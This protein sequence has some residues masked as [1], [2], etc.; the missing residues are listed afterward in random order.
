MSYKNHTSP[1]INGDFPSEWKLQSETKTKHTKTK[2][3]TTTTTTTN[4]KVWLEWRLFL[5]E[6]KPLRQIQGKGLVDLYN[7]MKFSTAF[8]QN[9]KGKTLFV[10][11]VTVNIAWSKQTWKER[12]HTAIF[13]LPASRLPCDNMHCSMTRITSISRRWETVADFDWVHANLLS[14]ALPSHDSIMLTF[15]SLYVCLSLSLFLWLNC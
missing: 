8:A 1:G 3:T 13:S 7:K 9:G 11:V 6:W 10:V 15:L 14:I 4:I 2:Q 12:D 5:S